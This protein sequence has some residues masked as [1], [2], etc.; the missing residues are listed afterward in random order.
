[1]ESLKLKNYCVLTVEEEIN[2]QLFLLTKK[3]MSNFFSPVVFIYSGLIN[4]IQCTE[5]GNTFLNIYYFGI[6]DRML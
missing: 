2:Q 4:K 6:F 3:D 1:M 5:E